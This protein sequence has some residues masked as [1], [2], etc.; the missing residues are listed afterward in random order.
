MC[1]NQGRR[2]RR[3]DGGSGGAGV[4]S[5]DMEIRGTKELMEMKREKIEMAYISRAKMVK[6]MHK[7]NATAPGLFIT[8]GG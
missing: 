3:R 8:W 5:A 4:Q 7:F 2:R 1:A 6:T